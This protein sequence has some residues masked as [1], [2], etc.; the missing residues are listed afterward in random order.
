MVLPRVKTYAIPRISSISDRGGR[1]KP[2]FSWL[3]RRRV[4]NRISEML[5]VVQRA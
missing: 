5:D 1:P 2:L 3:Y 4:L